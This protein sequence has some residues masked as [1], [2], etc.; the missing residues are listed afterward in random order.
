VVIKNLAGKRRKARVEV[1]VLPRA[2]CL[3]VR[4]QMNSQSPGEIAIQQ[5]FQDRQL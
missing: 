3:N 5:A 2:S 1:V 4:R